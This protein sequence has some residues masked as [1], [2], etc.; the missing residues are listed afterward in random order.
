MDPE[1]CVNLFQ[2][3]NV[4]ATFTVVSTSAAGL[5]HGIS[6]DEARPGATAYEFAVTH[7]EV[8]GIVVF[9]ILLRFKTCFDDHY[10]FGDRHSGPRDYWTL[11]GFLLGLLSWATWIISGS[12]SYNARYAAFWL[13]V[14][15]GIS[16]I[17]IVLHFLEVAIH[18]QSAN[19]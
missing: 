8:I 14:T 18:G 12:L 2:R 15:I 5:V 7:R 9:S 3:V 11:I 13:L 1:Y 4:T 17:W 6:G 10:Y 16:T 19:L